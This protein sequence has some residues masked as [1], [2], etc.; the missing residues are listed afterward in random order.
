MPRVGFLTA[1]DRQG[2]HLQMF[3]LNYEAEVEFTEITGDGMLRQP[4]FKGLL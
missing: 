3:A 1:N 4:S 2:R